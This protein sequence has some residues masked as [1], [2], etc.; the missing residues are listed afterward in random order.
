MHLN[1][2]TPGIFAA[3]KA[4]NLDAPD[5][6]VLEKSKALESVRFN[7]IEVDPELDE[8][9]R[10]NYGPEFYHSPIA[11]WI[12]S[13]YSEKKGKIMRVEMFDFE[14]IPKGSG[15]GLHD[16]ASIGT[17]SPGRIVRSRFFNCHHEFTLIVESEKGFWIASYWDK[18]R[19]SF[20]KIRLHV[21][22]IAKL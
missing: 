8:L 19:E 3:F 6:I 9:I 18:S 21:N 16:P 13:Y 15:S 2:S 4:G 10:A 14:L 7:P 22:E 11:D 17:L 1:Q 20:R 5:L 12:C